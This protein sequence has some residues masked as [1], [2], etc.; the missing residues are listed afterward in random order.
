MSLLMDALHQA[1]FS[2]QHKPM[3]KKDDSVIGDENVAIQ[4]PVLADDVH[5]LDWNPALIPSA[6]A[7]VIKVNHLDLPNSPTAENVS[8]EQDNDILRW[9][10]DLICETTATMTVSEDELIL[11]DDSTTSSSTSL[12]DVSDTSV[13]TAL[14]WDDAL[15]LVDDEVLEL[16][17][18]GEI[19]NKETRL[20]WADELF[21]QSSREL[22]D[23]PSRSS[24]DSSQTSH[25]LESRSAHQLYLTMG[26]EN[27]E[28]PITTE[29]RDAS[30]TARA[31][32]PDTSEETTEKTVDKATHLTWDDAIFSTPHP[33][34]AERQHNVHRIL[35]ASSA[36]PVNTQSYWA[37]A[38]LGLFLGVAGLYYFD[39][40]VSDTMLSA[41]N[42][43][44]NAQHNPIPLQAHARSNQPSQIVPL[45][46]EPM[47]IGISEEGDLNDSEANGTTQAEKLSTD[48]KPTLTIPKASSLLSARD[49]NNALL[50]LL[51]LKSATQNSATETVTSTNSPPSPTVTTTNPTSSVSAHTVDAEVEKI[52]IRR[53]VRNKNELVSHLT[54]AYTALQQ[55]NL[56]TA[57]R[58][59][60]QVLQ[61][62]ANNRDALLGMAAI[63]SKQQQANLA[64]T[65]YQRVLN[66]YPQD[67]VAKMGLLQ[68]LPTQDIEQQKN[69]LKQLLQEQPQAAYLHFGLGNAYA[70][71]G[72][73][74]SAQEAYF[75]AYR[76]DK[77]KAD[78]AYNLAVSL[79][80]LNKPQLAIPYYQ[81][82]L[83]LA[84]QQA[85]SFDPHALQTYLADL[86]IALPT[87]Q[88]TDALSE[89]ANSH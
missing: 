17:P 23:T 61:Q 10:A 83:Q 47:H 49:T 39:N 20:V 37:I 28:S 68:I 70:T 19:D 43:T 21:I 85:V 51:A 22:D 53:T 45:T 32:T 35:S 60:L 84:S 67:P 3:D 52:S 72:Q 29:N 15:K 79:E 65:Y 14:V 81:Q 24:P 50:N 9:D 59:Y 62:D 6:E 64:K 25:D 76:Y 27:S 54:T 74:R 75:N 57:N 34:V 1:E 44:G 87:N 55:G 5:V 16:E 8:N 26:D 86:N 71:Q 33:S 56:T 31:F 4:T 2:K 38:G 40:I 13:E 89:L 63:A 80:H 7:L 82:A 41:K 48:E 69:Q 12:Q 11:I 77:Q 30:P 36:R 73:W 18:N 66:H 58:Y 78:Y 46:I 88:T 42:I